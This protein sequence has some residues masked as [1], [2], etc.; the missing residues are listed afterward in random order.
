MIDIHCTGVLA[1][2]ESAVK[3]EVHY[4]MNTNA[5]VADRPPP[6]PFLAGH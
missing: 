2:V 3:D 1:P 5:Q 6:N 4:Q